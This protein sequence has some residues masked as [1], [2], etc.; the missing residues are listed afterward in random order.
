MEKLLGGKAIRNDDCHQGCYVRRLKETGALLL[1]LAGRS[2]SH[3]L[4]SSV[5]LSFLSDAGS[6]GLG[7][8]GAGV[9]YSRDLEVCYEGRGERHRGGDMMLDRCQRDQ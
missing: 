5:S 1:L 7:I 2:D 3:G 6:N 8:E 4:S 9:K